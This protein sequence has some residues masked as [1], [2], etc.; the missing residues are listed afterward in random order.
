MDAAAQ[1]FSKDN[2]HTSIDYFMDKLHAVMLQIHQ[3]RLKKEEIAQSRSEKLN[4]DIERLEK[5]YE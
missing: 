4:A 3:K 1:L 5:K 2:P